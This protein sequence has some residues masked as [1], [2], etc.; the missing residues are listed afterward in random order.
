MSLSK[1]GRRHAGVRN[2]RKSFNRARVLLCRGASEPHFGRTSPSKLL[3]AAT[4]QYSCSLGRRPGKRPRW[5]RLAWLHSTKA[6]LTPAA[7]AQLCNEPCIGLYFFGLLQALLALVALKMP[8]R[9]LGPSPTK[10]TSNFQ[11][12]QSCNFLDDT[13]LAKGTF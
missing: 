8:D 4:E 9:S 5:R 3:A 11:Q 13:R 7:H 2:H 6:C 12:H 10:L 1:R